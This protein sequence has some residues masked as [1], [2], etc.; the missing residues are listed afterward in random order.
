[1]KIAFETECPMMF[2]REDSAV[3]PKTRPALTQES[4]APTGAELA[5]LGF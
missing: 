5:V 4:G 3:E 1:M 2:E